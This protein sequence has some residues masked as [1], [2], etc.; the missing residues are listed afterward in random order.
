MHGSVPAQLCASGA[1]LILTDVS[2]VRLS[3][4]GFLRLVG[5]KEAALLYA[6]FDSRGEAAV[7]K[8]LDP[9]LFTK[10]FG[11]SRGLFQKPLAGIGA[12]PHASAFLFCELFSL[13]LLL[14]K[15]KADK[16]LPLTSSR[17]LLHR[18]RRRFFYG[19]FSYSAL[20]ARASLFVSANFILMLLFATRRK[21]T[22]RLVPFKGMAR[23]P[24][25]DNPYR[26]M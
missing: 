10:R 8:F 12:A 20:R 4:R 5:R 23:R 2:P 18:C 16:Q 7:L 19:A 6:D 21:G 17:R 24:S 22:K 25:L 11:G 26:L 13:R 3:Y 14:A 15:R 9:N 1:Y